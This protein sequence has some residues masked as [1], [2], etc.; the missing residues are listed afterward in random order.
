MRLANDKGEVEK[1]IPGRKRN[2]KE[3]KKKERESDR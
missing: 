3:R 1:V 2:M